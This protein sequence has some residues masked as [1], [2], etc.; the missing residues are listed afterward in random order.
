[1][2]VFGC[3]AFEVDSVRM[4][5]LVFL[6]AWGFRI[7]RLESPW[8]YWVTRWLCSLHPVVTAQLDVISACGA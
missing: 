1:M 7:R 6:R 8:A 3:C 5:V 2:P 4:R